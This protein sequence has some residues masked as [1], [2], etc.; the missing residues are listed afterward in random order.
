MTSGMF[1]NRTSGNGRNFKAARQRESRDMLNR[2]ADRLAEHGDVKR[3]AAQLG[4]SP[5]WGAAQLAAIRKGL[6]DQAC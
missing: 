2:F 5:A 4:R 1:S 6:G 3:A